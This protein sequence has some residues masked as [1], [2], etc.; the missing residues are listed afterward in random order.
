M[1]V[2]LQTQKV[3]KVQFTNSNM[4]KACVYRQIH[5]CHKAVEVLCLGQ[6]FAGAAWCQ[7]GGCCA[8]RPTHGALRC[9]VHTSLTGGA[10]ASVC[11]A[12]SMTST[13]QPPNHMKVH[14][15]VPPPSEITIHLQSGECLCW[16]G[17]GM[18]G[19]C[20]VGISLIN[21]ILG[22]IVVV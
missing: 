17:A 15:A 14:T 18:V 1:H 4:Q 6:C 9:T 7:W 13:V 3:A 10:A 19:V 5:I 11:Y 8:Q 2:Y 22:G 20:W 16:E 12:A 21:R